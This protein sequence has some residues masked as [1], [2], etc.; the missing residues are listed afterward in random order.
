MGLSRLSLFAFAP[1]RVCGCASGKNK[2]LAGDKERYATQV[3]ESIT[4]VVSPTYS[5][6]IDQKSVQI[7][8]GSKENETDS[9][10]W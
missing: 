6:M 1:C 3:A 2:D 10:F 5:Y 4:P 8:Q 9:R 7:L